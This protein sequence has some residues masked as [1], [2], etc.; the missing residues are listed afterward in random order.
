M[1][2]VSGYKKF[3]KYI[4]TSSGFQL[5]SHWTKAN[6]LEFDDGKTAQAKLGAIDGISSSRESNSD[7]IAASTALVSELNSDLSCRYNAATDMIQVKINGVWT[8]SI[9]ADVNTRYV[10]RYG[11]EYDLLTPCYNSFHSSF[12]TLVKNTSDLK[13]S[14]NSVSGWHPLAAFGTV[15][16]INLSSYSRIEVDYKNCSFSNADCS[17]VIQVGTARA[18]GN[19][20]EL[21]KRMSW[22]ST[23]TYTA[24]LDISDV[25]GE[26][27]IDIGL[28]GSPDGVWSGNGY[29]GTATVYVT[30]IR[31]IK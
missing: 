17:G 10:Y 6:T 4:L 25:T 20:A 7:K 21:T 19:L 9:R 24:S 28:K 15:N 14:V 13:I 5:V 23:G 2:I 31:L 1:S 27:Y 11:T 22:Y 16:Q 30:S 12:V 18:N 3:K 29:V 8:D 26:Q